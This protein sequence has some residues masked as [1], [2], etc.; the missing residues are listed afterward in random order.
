MVRGLPTIGGALLALPL[1]L[2]AQSAPGAPP[3]ALRDPSERLI[4]EQQERERTPTLRPQ[5]VPDAPAD[6][7]PKDDRYAPF[8][9]HLKVDGPAFAVGRIES[10]GELLFSEEEF[11]RIASVFEGQTLAAV[12]I[13][14]LLDRMTRALVAAGYITSRAAVDAQ[15]IAQGR[16]RVSVQAGRIER[17]RYNGQDIGAQDPSSA[18][19][20]PFSAFA[21]LG[22]RMALPMARGDV[23]RLQDIE[24]AVDQ[25]NRLR[26]NGVQVQILPGEQA[27]G[28]IL[29]FTN[30]EGDARGYTLS[31]DNQGASNTGRMRI[32][33][34]LEQGNALGLM[35]SLSLGMVT[36]T[37]S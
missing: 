37:E 29:E 20:A 21:H 33:A 27:G 23:L 16:L 10:A 4:R 6:K 2:L 11:R 5:A 13:Q 1:Q 19:S 28:S 12:H 18:P 15:S 26:R 24:Q 34:A 8:P 7:E 14:A 32:Q 17:I 25:I 31:I 9:A 30:K 36:S 3:A 35:E 22:V